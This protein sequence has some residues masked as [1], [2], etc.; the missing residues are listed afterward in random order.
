M[1]MTITSFLNFEGAKN[2]LLDDDLLFRT[3]L[4]NKSFYESLIDYTYWL[5][6]IQ[7]QTKQNKKVFSTWRANVFGIFFCAVH[8]NTYTLRYNILCC[9]YI[10]S[11]KKNVLIITKVFLSLKSML[12]VVGHS[13]NIYFYII[14]SILVLNAPN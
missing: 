13:L 11:W 12:F 7:Q 6:M 14:N 5:Q 2:I 1:Y 10:Y 4:Q 8:H 9:I 3:E